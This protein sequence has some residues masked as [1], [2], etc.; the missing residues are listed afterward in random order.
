VFTPRGNIV[1][2][3][4]FYMINPT[5]GLWDDELIIGLF[6]SV[7]ANKILEILIPPSGMQ[8]F[9]ACYLTKMGLFTV[10]FAYH[11]EWDYQF[12]RHHPNVIDIGESQGSHV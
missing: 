2:N 12:G 4:V 10:Q 8:D 6:W 7:D 9:V 11:A 1:L 3:K 5:T